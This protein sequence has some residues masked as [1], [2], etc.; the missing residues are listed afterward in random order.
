V[1]KPRDIIPR[2]YRR[3]VRAGNVSMAQHGILL[4]LISTTLPE[5]MKTYQISESSASIVLAAGSLGFLLGP[6]LAGNFVDRFGPRFVVL[7]AI[8]LEALAF[9]VF[10]TASLFCIVI[11]AN[12]LLEFAASAVETSIN[13]IPSLIAPRHSAFALNRIQLYYS[14]G[15]LLSP[16]FAGAILKLTGDWRIVYWT[17]I[18]VTVP[19][20]TLHTTR[21][22]PHTLRGRAAQRPVPRVVIPPAARLPI[23]L[24]IL[25]IFFF[26]AG[27][28]GL[29]GWIVLYLRE[30][31]GFSIV[32]SS[33]GL[34]L[35]W[36]GMTVGRYFNAFLSMTIPVKKLVIYACFGAM[37]AGLGLTLA[38][39]PA[40][41]YVCLLLVG[42]F[43]SGVLPG[44]I[45]ELSRRYPRREG[46]VTGLLIVAAGAGPAVFQLVLGFV[47]E[48]LSLR[49]ALYIPPI[50][51]AIAGLAYL[52]TRDAGN[53]P[54]GSVDAGSMP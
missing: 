16:L 26:V 10:G 18:A 21:S 6:L 41:L 9:A 27:E 19:L 11:L 45:A 24:G 5:I 50:L 7:G 48:E 36:A 13:A 29:C 47:A 34:S 17:M 53:G 40:A 15:A 31:M 42:V 2:P 8:I 37:C 30:N 14:A 54:S 25:T 12:L 49:S 3:V 51:M 4:L 28:F 32:A 43:M 22:Y 23:F 44:V 52:G 35:I 1:K 39:N 33:V 20:L 46:F 38:R